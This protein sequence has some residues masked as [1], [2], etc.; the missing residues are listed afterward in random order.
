MKFLQTLAKVDFTS[1][2]NFVK[3]FRL[4]PN[5]SLT[6]LKRASLIRDQIL[7]KIL[8][9]HRET[10]DPENLR[11]F[12]DIVLSELDREEKDGYM[13]RKRID[14]ENLRQI[15][16]DLF[17]AGSETTTSVLTWCFAYLAACPDVQRQ[18]AKEREKVIGDRMP[19]WS[20]KGS[21]DYFEAVIQE[22]LR[23]GSV[24]PL[25]VPRKTIH[26]TEC[27]GHKIPAGTQVWYNM[28]SIHHDQKQWDEPF[29]FK[30]ERFIDGNGKLI[31]ATY[32]SFL[33]FGGGKRRCI[34]E[35]VARMEIFILLSNVLYRYDIVADGGAPDLE[36]EFGTVLK[37]KPFRIKVKHHNSCNLSNIS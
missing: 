26:S 34:G 35:S 17:F 31:R 11:D 37:P 22:A 20:D 3:F 15:F 24:V 2:V 18:I 29:S 23:M 4:F 36:G 8:K 30:P 14:D 32:Q 19:R 7:D 21:L 33:P 5:N 10:Y 1:I 13:A 16:S 28:W 9:E 12:T 6:E 27:G 25:A